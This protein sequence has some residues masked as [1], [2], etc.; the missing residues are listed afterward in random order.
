MR[1]KQLV[2]FFSSLLLLVLVFSLHNASA[3]EEDSKEVQ[4]LTG[5]QLALA[6]LE[7]PESA[8]RFVYDS[9]LDFTYPEAVRGIYVTGPSAGG[10]N[11]EE[12]TNLVETTDLNSMVIDVKEDHG[13]ITFA[14]PEDSPY[15]DIAEPFIDDP[16]AMLEE[17]EKKGIYPIARVVVFKD[18]LL[19]KE[20][21]ELSY[22]KNGEVWVNGK[23]EAFTNPF[24]KE[25]WEYN[26]GVAKKAA[27]LGFQE[28]QFDYVRFPE[29][30]GSRDDV[31][32]YSQGDYADLE[33]SDVDKRVK[34]VTDFVEFAEEELSGYDVDVS[35][36]IFGYAATIEEAP[37]IG[38]NFSKISSH[39]D[40]ISSMIYPSHWGPFFGMDVPDKHPYK[41]INEYA[42]VE[43]TVLNKLEDPPTSRPWIQ[44]FEAPWLYSGATKQYGKTEVEQQIKALQDNGINE[45]LIWNARNNYTANVDYTP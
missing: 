12:L 4:M 9:G 44:D 6:P 20:R 22:T 16:R 11:M 25:V 39:V 31:L 29:G 43:N 27:E 17:L 30:F 7:S 21:P 8:A 23:G 14:P 18:S 36:D 28:I 34:A 1:K 38:Q 13:N 45:Y 37:N 10:S 2:L 42:K 24:M 32:D 41:T 35:V 40:V 3:A 15:K 26:L 5:K 33:L 19:A